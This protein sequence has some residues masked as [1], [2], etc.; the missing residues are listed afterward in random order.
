MA[1]RIGINGFGRI[2]RMVLRRT[3]SLPDVEVVAVND[4]AHIGDLAYLLKYDSVHG[5]FPGTV[6]HEDKAIMVDGHAVPFTAE[7]DPA[8]IPWGQAGV[9]VVIECTGALRG[10]ADASGHLQGGARKVVI[11]APSDDVDATIVPGVNDAMYDR[12]QHQVVSMASCTTNSLAPV[13]KVL[14]EQFGIAQL[15]ITTVHAYTSSQ[16]IMDKPT[17]KRR[18]GRAG[19]LSMIPTSTGAAKATAL[20]LPALAGKVDGMAIRVPIPDGSVTDIVVQLDKATSAPEINA[21]LREA[22]QRPPLQGILEVNDEEIVSVDI[23]GNPHSSIVDAPST[24]VLNGK[25][26]KILAW[27]DNE[28]GYSCRLAELAGRLLA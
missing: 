27:Y 24:M 4:L 3:M 16:S 15:F 23:V 8:K 20:V 1:C 13:A 21:C 7:R 18:R 17:R 10:R 9:D 14:Q 28:W 25:T 22:S 2:G 11:S 5:R 6:T 12:A 26:A 19:A